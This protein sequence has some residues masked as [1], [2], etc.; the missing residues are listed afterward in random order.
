MIVPGAT[1]PEKGTTS[2]DRATPVEPVYHDDGE[3]N[4][5]EGLNILTSSCALTRRT[6][7]PEP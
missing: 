3:D 4:P 5:D 2:R 6:N 1:P 7:A